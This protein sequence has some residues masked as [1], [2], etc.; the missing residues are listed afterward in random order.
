MKEI[1]NPLVAN[2]DRSN[3]EIEI[4]VAKKYSKS[5]APVFEKFMGMCAM[6]DSYAVDTSKEDDKGTYKACSTLYDQAIKGLYE[7]IEANIFQNKKMLAGLTE[8]QKKNLPV[9]LQKAIV[10][11]LKSEG[12]ITEETDSTLYE[13]VGASASTLFTQKSKPGQV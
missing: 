11:K 2:V 12:K 13:P 3:G 10:K 8:K 9:E 4:S 7:R 6:Y 5:E 1:K